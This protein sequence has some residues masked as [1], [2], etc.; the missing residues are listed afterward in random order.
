MVIL[1]GSLSS[2]LFLL[3]VSLGLLFLSFGVFAQEFVVSDGDRVDVHISSNDITRIAISGEGRIEKVWG[4]KGVLSIDP[5]KDRGE[6]FIKPRPSAKGLMSFFVRDDSGNTYTIV[7][8]QSNVPSQTIILKP[9]KVVLPLLGNSSTQYKN[10][11]HVDGVKRLIRAMAL[12]GGVAGYSVEDHSVDVPLWREIS[13]THIRSYRGAKYIG[14]I[15]KV[16]NLTEESLVFHER[17]FFD[18]GVGVAAVSMESL[19]L[20]STDSTRLFVVRSTPEGGI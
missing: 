15:Y 3:L 17:E 19:R 7:A 18:F 10:S 5:D 16:V 20:I 2:S 14:D 11:T 6:V 8:Q 9:K 12:G 4:A 1:R 13:I